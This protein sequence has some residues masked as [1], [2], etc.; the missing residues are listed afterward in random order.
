[1]DSLFWEGATPRLPKS[2]AGAHFDQGAFSCRLEEVEAGAV[3]LTQQACGP[4]TLRPRPS[5]AYAT[6]ELLYSATSV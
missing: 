2:D 4:P 3:G 6:D 5:L 1:M